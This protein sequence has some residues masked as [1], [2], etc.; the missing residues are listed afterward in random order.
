MMKRGAK[1]AALFDSDPDPSDSA[2]RSKRVMDAP[3]FDGHRAESSR[4]N[5]MEGI[6]LDAKRAESARQHVRALNTQFASWIQLQLQNHPDELWEDGAKD[7]LSHASNILPDN[8]AA[9]KDIGVG[10]LSIKC[11]EGADKAAKESKPTIM[12]RNDAGRILLNALIYPGIKMN[13]K[14]NTIATI[15]HTSDGGPN[16]GVEAGKSNVVTR[17]YL[18]R[19]KTEDET[20]KLAAAIQDYAPSA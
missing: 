7:Y 14:K 1:V 8:S 18:L 6:K 20:T 13:I 16:D 5:R 3:S 11:Q 19:L 4:Q 17:T 2:L 9:W 10:Q 15:F 12:I